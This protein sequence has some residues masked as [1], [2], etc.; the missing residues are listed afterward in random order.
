MYKFSK[1][2]VLL[3]LIKPD[4]FYYGSLFRYKVYKIHNVTYKF[5]LFDNLLFIIFSLDILFDGATL[6]K[7]FHFIRIR[8][9]LKVIQ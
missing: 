9:K 1:S 6:S 8:R 2:D 5:A 3:N 7:W 4:F